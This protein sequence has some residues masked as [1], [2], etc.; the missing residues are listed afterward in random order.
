M[1]DLYSAKVL[2]HVNKPRNAGSL[3]DANVVVQADDPSC[4]DSLV[5]LPAS[6][7]IFN[8]ISNDRR[9]SPCLRVCL[10]GRSNG[11]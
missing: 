11:S 7:D 8:D 1:S 2:D 3:D 9:R 10:T 4:G 5:F 6:S